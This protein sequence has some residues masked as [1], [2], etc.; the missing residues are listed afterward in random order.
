MGEA[1]DDDGSGA[2][3]V[4]AEPHQVG[5]ALV[6]RFGDLVDRISFYL[7]YKAAPASPRPA[8]DHL[9]RA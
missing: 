8:V 5:V 6:E 1:I 7:P 4:V 3:A 2:F 9:R